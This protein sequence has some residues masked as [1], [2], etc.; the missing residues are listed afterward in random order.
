MCFSQPV[1][2]S[3]IPPSQ[4]LPSLLL[5]SPGPAPTLVSCASQTCCTPQ[6]EHEWSWGRLSWGRAGLLASSVHTWPPLWLPPPGQSGMG[7]GWV[8]SI[9]PL[10]KFP[11]WGALEVRGFAVGVHVGIVGCCGS[12][13]TWMSHQP[14]PC[15]TGGYLTTSSET[16]RPLASSSSCLISDLIPPLLIL[17]P[18]L[19]ITSHLSQTPSQ[20]SLSIFPSPYPTPP[21]SHPTPPYPLPS[22]LSTV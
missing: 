19:Q 10:P 22:F 2:S 18:P 15:R 9:F 16:G 7:A 14:N 20:P 5:F 6:E 4:S 3:S 8:P 1:F 13:W 12:A 21:D 17:I 11:S